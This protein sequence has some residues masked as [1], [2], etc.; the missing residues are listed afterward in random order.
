MDL[1]KYAEYV[2][3]GYEKLVMK[4]P[5]ASYSFARISPN[6]FSNVFH[7]VTRQD[8]ILSSQTLT[9]LFS[10]IHRTSFTRDIFHFT[11]WQSPRMNFAIGTTRGFF[12][13][14]RLLKLLQFLL[15]ILEVHTQVRGVRDPDCGRK[16]SESSLKN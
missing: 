2:A 16:I 6:A 4:T 8:H 7:T 14:Q 15:I 1:I 3:N 5:V 10:R 13:D 12:F 9:D 11:A